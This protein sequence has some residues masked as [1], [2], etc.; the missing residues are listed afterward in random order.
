MPDVPADHVGDGAAG[1]SPSGRPSSPSSTSSHQRGSAPRRPFARVLR[2]DLVDLVVGVRA[3]ARWRRTS[4]AR[5]PSRARCGSSAGTG[6]TAACPSSSRNTCAVHSCTARPAN[7]LG[8]SSTRDERVAAEHAAHRAAAAPT[9]RARSPS[10]T[11]ARRAAG[12]PSSGRACSAR[13]RGDL[14][15]ADRA[16]RRRRAAAA[17]S[18]RPTRVFGAV[19]RDRTTAGCRRRRPRRRCGTCRASAAVVRRHRMRLGDADARAQARDALVGDAS[20]RRPCRRSLIVDI[21]RNTVPTV[22]EALPDTIPS[23]VERAATKFADTEALVDEHARLT[24]VAA[25]ATR[26]VVAARGA[27]SRPASSPATASRSGRRTSPSGCIAAL[28]IYARRRASSS[29]ST[30]GSRAPKRRTSS[31]AP[32][33][34]LLFTVTDFL[35]TDYVDAAPQRRDPSPSLEQIVVLRGRRPRAT[36]SWDDV[37]R[38]RRSRRRARDRA[39]RGRGHAAAR[40][41]D[42]L[43]TSGT[44]GQPEGRDA[45]ARRERR[46]LRRVG[47]GRRP[48]R[49]AT[50]TCRQPVLPHLRA[51]GRASSRASSRARRSSRTRCS[52]S[53]R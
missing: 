48:A 22:T 43:F 53:P 13:D 2:V 32:S 44:T 34:K 9:T 24:F 23:I 26:P 3:R 51:E 12:R 6:P 27:R 52:T 5:A 25:R 33:A 10:R 1:P 17:R 36:V 35:D 45:H 7:S 4:C 37:P 50:A 19:R 14:V 8:L 18:A 20:R 41:S 39:P 31:T 42:I 28:G 15:L 38:G 46:G 49:T 30:P 16:C 21:V 11:R 40:L 47:D 29:R